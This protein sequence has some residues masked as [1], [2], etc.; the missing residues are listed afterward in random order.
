MA[1]VAK[2]ASS[3]PEVLLPCHQSQVTRDKGVRCSDHQAFD[4]TEV[5]A[6]SQ[7]LLIGSDV[8]KPDVTLAVDTACD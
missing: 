1:F 7:V 4:V 3:A 8:C 5:S 2:D 6:A